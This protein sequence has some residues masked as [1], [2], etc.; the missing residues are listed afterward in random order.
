MLVTFTFRAK[1]GKEEEFERLLNN[2]ESGRLFAK[3]MGAS[4]NALFLKEGRMIRVVEFPEGAQP[5]A[6]TD[7]M[8]RDPKVKEFLKKMGAIVEDGFDPDVPGS[9]EAFNRRVAV[10]LAYDVRV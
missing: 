1:P 10:P 7:I 2:P 5:V 8:E 3:A 4:R 6:M 9:L